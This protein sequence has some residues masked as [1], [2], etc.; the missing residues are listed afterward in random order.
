MKK[1]RKQVQ[2][3]RKSYFYSKQGEKGDVGESHT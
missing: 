2:I 1:R 3:Q